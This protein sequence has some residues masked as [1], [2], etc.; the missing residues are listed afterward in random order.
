MKIASQILIGYALVLI[1]FGIVT[2]VNRGLSERVNDNTEW[3]TRSENVIRLS[4][5][6]HRGILDME[7]A[8]RGYLLTGKETFL[9]PYYSGE[10]D[11][12]NLINE[13]SSLVKE[14]SFQ[15]I[16]LDTIN[17]FYNKWHNEFASSLIVAKQNVLESDE[18]EAEFRKL[19]IN[20]LRSEAGKNITDDIR[21]KFKQFNAHEYDLRQKRREILAKSVERTNN[22]SILLIAVSLFLGLS[23]ALYI[24]NNISNRIKEMV[25]AAERIAQGYFKV[26]VKDTKMDEMTSLSQSLNRM[27]ITLD[28][29]FT[30]LERKNSDLNQFAYVV[31]H[32]LKAP[33]RGIDN[34]MS[35]I[36][37]DV[38]DKLD[39]QAKHYLE[40]ISGRTKRMENLINGILDFSRIGRN[41]KPV[42]KVAVKEMLEEIIDSLAVPKDFSI[43]IKP[44]MP[45]LITERVYLEQVFSNLIS[46]AIKYHDEPNGHIEIGVNA[47]DNFYNFYVKDDGPGIEKEYHDRIFVIFQ[48]LQERDAFESTGVGLAIVKK[49]I[50]DKGGKIMV[51]SEPGQGATFSFT[52]PK[53]GE[54]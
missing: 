19:M 47:T 9:Q 33:L 34:V 23:G 21:N 26:E 44:G 13:L 41:K 4:A 46:N 15:R 48:T 30:D 51:E 10:K 18:A 24:T 40:M 6:V 22:I 12:P 53:F 50:D 45:T 52:W 27:A 38:G 31:S 42:E 28:E 7:N 49:I 3:L 8:M 20:E 2:F 39:P 17:A 16:K 43:E 32:D 54:Q 35:W 25:M 37:E 11:V 5:Q 29:T 36:Y 1:L 14:D